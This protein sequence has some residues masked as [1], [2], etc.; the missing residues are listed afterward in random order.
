MEPV[1]NPLLFDDCERPTPSST[2]CEESRE[3]RT[4]KRSRAA[5]YIA[6]KCGVS[7]AEMDRFAAQSHQR[8]AA[9]WQSGAFAAEVMP[10][11]VGSGAKSKTVSRD[12]GIRP[13]TSLEDGLARMWSWAV[14]RVAAP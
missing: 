14:A 11:T 13:E 2:E 6:T 7:R 8:A 1:L 3:T 9:A 10:V 12:E 4:H 5:E